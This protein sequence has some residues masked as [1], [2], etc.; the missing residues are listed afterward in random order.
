MGWLL[1]GT[2]KRALS[3]LYT[4]Y[5][6]HVHV[7]RLCAPAPNPDD[8]NASVEV[9]FQLE[10]GALR[11]TVMADLLAHILKDPFFDQLRTK[12]QLGYLV[13]SG[14]RLDC[15]VSSLRFILQVGLDGSSPAAPPCALQDPLV[16]CSRGQLYGCR[17]QRVC[18]LVHT[19]PSPVQSP[20]VTADELDRRIEEFIEGF[21]SALVA[22]SDEDFDR[23]RAA[24]TEPGEE[25]GGDVGGGLQWTWDEVD[26]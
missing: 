9:L 10:H 5:H 1:F 17:P 6:A 25:G 13:F 19:S 26:V 8:E 14:P 24:G 18:L 20:K 7:C 4:A 2:L 3:R 23:N 15:S 16:L 21:R 12:Q 22:M 11:N